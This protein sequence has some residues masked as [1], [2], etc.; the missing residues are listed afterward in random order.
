M[1]LLKTLKA[2]GSGESVSSKTAR[3]LPG[4]TDQAKINRPGNSIHHGLLVSSIR[5]VRC[6]SDRTVH[7]KSKYANKRAENSH[8]H[9]RR[10]ERQMQ[11]FKSA[12]QA[13]RF[14]GLHARVGNLFRYGQH[15]ISAKYHRM[16]RER[17]FTVWSLVV[18]AL[19]TATL[20]LLQLY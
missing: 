15:L 13:Q 12:G 18:R 4:T 5:L 6:V 10:R 9:T 7:Y 2:S 8:H 11:R 1:A 3:A 14:L 16:F 20:D 17:A 19:N